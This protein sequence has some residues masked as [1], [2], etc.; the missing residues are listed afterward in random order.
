MQL[1]DIVEQARLFNLITVNPRPSRKTNLLFIL[2]GSCAC[3]LALGK[4][5]HMDETG[6]TILRILSQRTNDEVAREFVK[7]KSDVRPDEAS[8]QQS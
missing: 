6:W 8:V 2:Q 4:R 3:W 1:K 7:M 5:C